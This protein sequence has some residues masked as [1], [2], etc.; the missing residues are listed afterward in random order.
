MKLKLIL[1]S[2]FVSLM[3]FSVNPCNAAEENRID[4]TFESYIDSANEGSWTSKNPIITEGSGNK[5]AAFGAGTGLQSMYAKNSGFTPDVTGLIAN[6]SIK[7]TGDVKQHIIFGAA[8]STVPSAG[9]FRVLQFYSGGA[10]MQ[11][12]A[13]SKYDI[14]YSYTTDVWYDVS[15]RLNYHTGYYEL[16]IDNGSD[17]KTWVKTVPELIRSTDDNKKNLNYFV[18]WIDKVANEGVYI[19]N[20]NIFGTTDERIYPAVSDVYE[21]DSFQSADGTSVP[22]GFISSGELG[23]G[24][25]FFGANGAVKLVSAADKALLLKKVFGTSIT[26]PNVTVS[27]AE[28]SDCS[29]ELTAADSMGEIETL[30]VTPDGVSVGDA[31]AAY[32]MSGDEN[33]SFTVKGGKLTAIVYDNDGFA[34]AEAETALADLKEFA[35]SSPEGET[36]D[37][38]L[39]KL[40]FATSTFFEAVSTSVDGGKI[41]PDTNTIT[42]NFSN[43]LVPGN[44]GSFILNGDAT[45]ERIIY[46]EKS[47]E[48]ILDKKLS[49]SS[50]YMLIYEDVYDI[51]G[52][53]VS[54][55]VAFRTDEA[56]EGEAFEIISDNENYTINAKLRSNT[57]EAVDAVLLITAYDNA[58]G[59]IVSMDFKYVELTSSNQD[60][61][62]SVSK[63]RCESYTIEA[64]LWNS[65]EN[66]DSLGFTAI[67]GGVE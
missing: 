60:F 28:A 53:N 42:V 5:C 32:A 3:L 31:T 65:F 51:E 4:D 15:I 19:D 36:C 56:V 23:V 63:P 24:N 39:S 41:R 6:F 48:L 52:Y 14:S 50:E 46:G 66:M 59:K 1:T 30:A 25:G 44:N 12:C 58:T 11:L 7:F 26:P 9:A 22:G 18:F 40:A 49:P 47:V 27:L 35:V 17:S 43:K 62:A 13:L 16:T 57:G 37:I 38:T 29:F 2:L 10:K 8:T 20:V 21:F 54:G 45:V 33:I 55:E 34:V 67:S 61:T 64:Y